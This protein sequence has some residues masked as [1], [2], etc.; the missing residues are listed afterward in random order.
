[1]STD[2]IRY[3]LEKNDDL[4]A[5]MRYERDWLTP[6]LHGKCASVTNRVHIA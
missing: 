1:M 6:S 2:S 5:F 4:F 3:I